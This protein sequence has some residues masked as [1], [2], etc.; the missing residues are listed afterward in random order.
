[1]RTHKDL[2]VWKHGINLAKDI[3]I[4]TGDFPK[5]EMYGIASQMRRAA[6]SVPSNIAEGA[7]RNGTKEFRNFLYIAVSSA[8]E[9][10][11]QIEIAKQVGLGDTDKLNAL[12]L[13]LTQIIQMLYGLIRSI[14]LRS[15][16]R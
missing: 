8:T 5:Q 12:Q 1:M 4:V 6:V 14:K 10:D 11:T 16:N 2:D 13:R 7:A 3:Y 9:L 15:G